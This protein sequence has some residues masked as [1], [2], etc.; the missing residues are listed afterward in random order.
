MVVVTA[1]MILKP[2]LSSMNLS[3]LVSRHVK[4]REVGSAGLQRMSLVNM[5]P[6]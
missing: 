5:L 3:L 1:K 4:A 6:K 2:S